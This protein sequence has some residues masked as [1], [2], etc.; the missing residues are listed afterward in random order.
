ME[1]LTEL[2]YNA[3]AGYARSPWTWIA[4][5]ELE[6]YS[7]GNEKVLGVIIQDRTD[8]D[9]SCVVMGRDRIG[10][11]RAVH[12]SPFVGTVGKARSAA[13]ELLAEYALKDPREFEQ[14]DEPSAR[15]N[16]FQPV[17]M[18]YGR[19]PLFARSRPSWSS[20]LRKASWKR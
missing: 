16:F 19:I 20:P 3:L 15:V 2:R 12:L 4:S 6:W 18:F 9:Y 1:R 14:G 8:L 5:N 7:E 13:S 11:Y 10:R 17:M